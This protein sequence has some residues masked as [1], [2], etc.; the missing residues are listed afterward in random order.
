MPT[1]KSASRIAS[2]LSSYAKPTLGMCSHL[3]R[4]SSRPDSKGGD[5]LHQQNQ[6]LVTSRPGAGPRPCSRSPCP[7]P[8]G[9]GVAR[10][11]PRKFPR[12]PIRQP[13]GDDS[14]SIL[15]SSPPDHVVRPAT[16]TEDG[17]TQER[18]PG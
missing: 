5:D 14:P 11:D 17:S 12:P 9:E 8:Q 10:C 4:T 6:N 18:G 1:R 2:P 15:R 13:T 3:T 16:A 7:L